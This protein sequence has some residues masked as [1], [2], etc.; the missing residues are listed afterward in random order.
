MNKSV[1]FFTIGCRLN[2]AETAILQQAFEQEGFTYV[3]F[4]QTSDLVVVNTCTVTE[5]GDAETRKVVNR[6]RRDNPQAQIALVGCQAQTQK[7]KLLDLPGVSWVVG[8]EIKMDLPRFLL[9]HLNEPG[10][11]TPRIQRKSFT[12]P[13]A[14]IDRKHTRANLKIQDGCDYFCSYC[15]IPFARGLARSRVFDD[16]V[17]E[18]GILAQAGHKELVLTGINVGTYS[19]EGKNIA[20]VIAALDK[21]PGLERIRISSIEAT[22]LPGDLIEFM[23]KDR[24]LCRFLHIS[25]QSGSDK[26]LELMNRKYTLKEYADFIN[27]AYTQVQDIC[28][29]T[30]VIVGFP[31]ETDSDFDDTFEYMKSLPLTYFHVFSYSDRDHARSRKFSGKVDKDTIKKRNQ[32]LRDLSKEKRKK[33]L[34]NQV[35]K[36][37]LVL[38]E[39]KKKGLWQ[40]HTDTFI[41]VKVESDLDLYNRIVP[42]ELDNVNDQFMTGKI[43]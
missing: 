14:G 4:G 19:Y 21:V 33:Y 24:K 30:D 1:S 9:D 8:N 12:I 36:T 2:Q 7:E 13:V 32:I 22:T 26:I 11:F 20:D 23:A 27:L 28:L 37:E 38:F 5:N 25:L 42:V 16:L 29:G 34:N 35:G 17:H 41:H 39:H 15:E 10:V 40:G 43:L 3:N 31:G 18:A 6:I